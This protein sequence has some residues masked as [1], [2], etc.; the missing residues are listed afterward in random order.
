MSASDTLCVSTANSGIAVPAGKE[1]KQLQDRIRS[2]ALYNPDLAPIAESQRSWGTWNY[3]ALWLSMS[4]VITT[5]TLASGLM[6]AGMSWWQALLTVGL[7]N[8]LVLIPM[9]LNA[10]V[11]TRYG[12]PFPVVIRAAFGTQGAKVAAMARGLVGCGW[13]G[14]Q[15]WLGGLALSALLGSLWTNWRQIPGHAFWAFG[16]FWI[17]QMAIVWRGMAAIKRLES[18]AAPVLISLLL[19]LFLWALQS[20][21]GV[22]HTLQAASMLTSHNRPSF[23]LLFWPGL[24]ANVGYWATLS[25]NIPDFTRFAKNQRSQVVGQS[26]GLPVGMILTSFVGIFVTAAALVKFHKPLWNPIDLIPRI[27]HNGLLLVIAILAILL[28]QTSINM[29]ANVVSPSNDF[30][31]LAPK[32]VSFRIGGIITGIIGIL[33]CPWAL[34][35]HAS[36]YV[37]T[38]LAGCGSI[39]GAVAG[40]MI[41]D[42]WLWRGRHLS[43]EGLYQEDACYQRWNWTAFAALATAILPILPGFWHVA[44]SVAHVTPGSWIDHLYTYGWFWTFSVAGGS[45]LLFARLWQP[46]RR[47]QYD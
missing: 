22:Q 21:H 39:L 1:L 9:I 31:N 29:G 36:T 8:F 11:G 34:M 17:V 24:A 23:W 32:W 26:I 28:A 35:A 33:I 25:L 46:A 45:Y 5:Y 7:G 2:S 4:A 30:A 20:G 14:I 37:F 43:L 16:L 38:W 13:F 42:Y 44:S 12:V 10:A 40:V 47:L 3:L 41:S 15:T 19:A 27:T 18:F 6:V